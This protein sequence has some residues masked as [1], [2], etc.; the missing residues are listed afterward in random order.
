M[1]ALGKKAMHDPVA[2]NVHID[3]LGPQV[4]TLFFH[5]L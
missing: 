1:A 2:K 4:W 5:N 3:T